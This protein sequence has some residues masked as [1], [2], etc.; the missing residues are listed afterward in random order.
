MKRWCYS[1]KFNSLIYRYLNII[2]SVDKAIKFI[3]VTPAFHLSTAKARAALPDQY[4]KKD[5]IF[6]LQRVAILVGG[7]SSINNK[8]LLREAMKDKVHQ[9][10]RAK[11]IPGLEKILELKNDLELQSKGLIGLTL[12]GSGPTILAIVEDRNNIANF[13]AISTKIEQI[14]KQHELNSTTRTLSLSPQGA[15]LNRTTSKI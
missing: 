3:A 9:P 10:Y 4:S 6:N 15:L 14:F 2:R 11:L 7:L 8:D 12:S 13:T 1:Y 5:T